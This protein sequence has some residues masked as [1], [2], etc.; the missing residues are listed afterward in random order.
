MVAFTSGADEPRP[1]PLADVPRAL[2]DFRGNLHCLGLP[3]HIGHTESTH[4]AT[5][6]DFEAIASKEVATATSLMPMNQ[7][8]NLS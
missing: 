1:A 6:E 7:R 4:A 2:G 8:W 5:A 3:P